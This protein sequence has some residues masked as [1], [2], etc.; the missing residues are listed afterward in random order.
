MDRLRE[1]GS[2][3][4]LTTHY[5]EEAQQRADRIGLMHKG[6][7]HQG[8]TVAELTRTLPAVIRFGLPPG[9]PSR[10][11]G[12]LNGAYLIETFGLQ[13]D[14]H[15]LLAGRTT[16]GWS[17]TSAGPTRLDDVFRAIDDRTSTTER[18]PTMLSIA[19]SELIQ[20]FRN[21]LVLVTGLVMPVAVSA[22]FVYQHECSPTSAASATSRRS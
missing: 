7:L 9:A 13:E 16:T 11:R 3:V 1:E 18:T 14:L 5:L 8:G 4:V 22:Y 12:P 20:I 10:R 21:R 2:T 17:W 19:R 15:S 6:T